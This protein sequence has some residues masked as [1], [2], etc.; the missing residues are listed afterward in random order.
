M[1]DSKINVDM[2]AAGIQKERQEAN[3]LTVTAAGIC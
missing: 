2:E 1:S 3:T